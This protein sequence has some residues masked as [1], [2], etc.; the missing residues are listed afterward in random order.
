MDV[1]N[2]REPISA[3]THFS[4]LML[5]VPAS[6]LLCLRC[7]GQLAKQAC[8]VIYGLSLAAGYGGS[9]FYHAVRLPHDIVEGR[10]QNLDYIG[11]YLMIAGNVT[12]LAVAAL[13]GHWRRALLTLTWGL[14]TVGIIVRACNLY[15]PRDVS[16]CVYLGMGWGVLLCY[17]QL[18]RKLTH[19][20]LR[21]L[22]LGGV[23]YTV[24]AV[25]NH[26]GWPTLWPGI[27][28]NHDLYHLFVMA[29]TAL[30]FA[31]MW[32]TLAPYRGVAP[33]RP[34]P[35]ARGRDVT[36]PAATTAIALLKT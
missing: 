16:V 5:A 30:H 36:A 2:F 25:M 18:G 1:L 24:G 17:F 26:F 29:G 14:A 10:C 6:I 9:T 20:R 13:S 12:P 31:F 3:W 15:V 11:I 4:W 28:C 8:F 35:A 34:T 19:R 23:I 21:L 33:V 32:R 27:F 22:L 7:R